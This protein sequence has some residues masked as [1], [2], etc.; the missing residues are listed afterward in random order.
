MRGML[1][2]VMVGRVIGLSDSLFGF[3]VV[4]SVKV[5]GIVERRAVIDYNG[6]ELQTRLAVG[7]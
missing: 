1:G 2:G 5:I 4:E 7:C 6:S 3:R